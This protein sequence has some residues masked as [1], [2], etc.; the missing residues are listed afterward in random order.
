MSGPRGGTLLQDIKDILAGFNV[1]EDVIS[2]ISFNCNTKAAAAF[3]PVK[4][5]T[6]GIKPTLMKKT[7]KALGTNLN[8]TSLRL[9][10]DFPLQMGMQ[11]TLEPLSNDPKKQFFINVVFQTKDMKA[12][13]TFVRGFGENTIQDIIGALTNE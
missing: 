9:G 12:L 2:L 4:G 8:V 5:L 11:L 7:M 10:T 3:D 6:D 13:D 1:V